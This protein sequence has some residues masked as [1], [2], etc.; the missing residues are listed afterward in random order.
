VRKGINGEKLILQKLLEGNEKRF[1]CTQKNAEITSFLLPLTPFSSIY[2]LAL[3]Q[4]SLYL[5]NYLST[6]D[7]DF[8]ANKSSG[9]VNYHEKERKKR[10]GGGEE[11]HFLS[12]F[13]AQ[14][15]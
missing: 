10:G 1:V 15:T 9:N 12:Y 6:P 5:L 14:S 7:T 13:L 11:I 3:F 2:P 8:R 4:Q